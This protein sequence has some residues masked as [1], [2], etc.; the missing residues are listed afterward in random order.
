ML[1]KDELSRVPVDFNLYQ[2]EKDYLQHIILARIYSRAGNEL[3]FKGDTSLQKTF[4]LNRFSED[5]DF[6]HT[7]GFE[8]DK[9]ERGLDELERFYPTTYEKAEKRLSVNYRIKIEGP[10]FKGPQSMQTVRID[11]S[12]RERVLRDPAL[13][14]V[15]P[16]YND[17]QP[18][19][20]VVM[21]HE[22]ILSEKI[23]ALLTRSKARDLYDTYF[24]IQKGISIDLPMVQKKLEFYEVKY[25]SELL[26]GRILKLSDQWN[27][28]LSSLVRVKP[29][30]ELVVSTVF[31]ILDEIQ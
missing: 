8:L 7:K 17:I 18:Y 12:V 10:L 19:L 1:T 23:R 30:F 22:E 27:R 21:D 2:K 16:L 31:R 20:L 24:M 26:K 29:S 6:T 13:K 11:I 28:E 9:I 3:V 25:N 15:T 14:F 5:L 4:G